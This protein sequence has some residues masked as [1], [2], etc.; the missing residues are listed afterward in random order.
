M[1]SKRELHYKKLNR[2]FCIFVTLISFVL[3]CYY[4]SIKDMYHTIIS[5]ASPFFLFAPMLLNRLFR[6]KTVYQLSFALNFYSFLAFTGGM[7]L[8][9]YHTLPYYD[10][11][12][13]TISGFFF[14]LI[15]LIIYY[16]L[17]PQKIIDKKE[18]ALASV[19]AVSFSMAIAGFWEIYEYVLDLLTA[20]D[21]QNVA[22]TG[23]HD[24]MQDIIVCLIG[25]LL[26]LLPAFRYYKKNKTGLFMGILEQFFLSNMK[27]KS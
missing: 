10:K 21:S 2:I 5:F 25:A 12:V 17:K 16:Y 22:S 24:T 13:H 6:L 18:F 1:N 3:F 19:F 4:V 9:L 15:G 26:F 8:A 23:I 11:A 20:V 27:H 14:A 7:A